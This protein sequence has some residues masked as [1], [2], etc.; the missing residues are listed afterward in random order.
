MYVCCPGWDGSAGL[1]AQH[2]GIEEPIRAGDVRNDLDKYKVK[3]AGS[4]G[5][6]E[7]GG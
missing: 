1:G 4:Y 2:Q 5:R 3:G 6:E 7:G